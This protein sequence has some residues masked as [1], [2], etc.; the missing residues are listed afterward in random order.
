MRI[1][2]KVGVLCDR[3]LSHFCRFS[4]KLR[5]LAKLNIR[6]HNIQGSERP[7]FL[8]THTHIHPKQDGRKRTNQ[9]FHL[10]PQGASK[11]LQDIGI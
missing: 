10:A 11:A 4:P 8:S 5:I 3:E 2:K 9:N 1:P 7:D 6:L